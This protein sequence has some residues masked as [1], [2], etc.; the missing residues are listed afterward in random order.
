MRKA[1]I[2][3]R[4]SP[5]PLPGAVYSQGIKVQG[6]GTL[7]FVSGHTS[8]DPRTGRVL[9]RGDITG[10]TRQALR[11]VQAVLEAAGAR[12]SD[13]VKVTVFVTHL[14]RHFKAIHEVRREFF[15]KDFPAS[16]MVE[17]KGLSDPALMIEIDAVAA[18]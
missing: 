7:V 2:T 14:R 3:S 8:R 10:Q 6:A 17:I 13:V 16:T 1:V 9:H 18:R 12:M 4:R 11:N 5:Q 15:T